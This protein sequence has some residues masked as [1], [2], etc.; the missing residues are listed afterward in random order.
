MIL[1][2]KRDNHIRYLVIE[3]RFSL[4]W[5]WSVTNIINNNEFITYFS[6]MVCF[7]RLA[8]SAKVSLE[9]TIPR[10][11]LARH[12][13]MGAY[14]SKQKTFGCLGKLRGFRGSFKGPRSSRGLDTLKNIFLALEIRNKHITPFYYFITFI[15]SVR[16]QEKFYTAHLFILATYYFA[17]DQMFILF[18][19]E[20][21]RISH[22]CMKY[23]LA[24]SYAFI[25]I[26]LMQI[27]QLLNH[28][29][30]FISSLADRFSLIFSFRYLKKNTD[31]KESNRLLVS[32][33]SIDVLKYFKRLCFGC[34]VMCKFFN[35]GS[36]Y[37]IKR[38]YTVWQCVLFH[39]SST[40]NI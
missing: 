8:N 36:Q 28:L 5:Y 16:F 18:S 11:F 19:K 6:A 10:G 32:A 20:M 9:L 23:T 13:K 12:L 31:F 25:D 39:K 14:F 15:R 38:I 27:I 1:Y 26:A 17:L 30:H 22:Q 34:S 33:V 2:N 7:K 37:K 24:V 3:N 40:M 35:T 29:K 21:P 4:L